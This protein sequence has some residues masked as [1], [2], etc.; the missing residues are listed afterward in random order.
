MQTDHRIHRDAETTRNE[1]VDR[2]AF[3]GCPSAHGQ[4]HLRREPAREDRPGDARSCVVPAAS[5]A[6]RDTTGRRRGSLRRRSQPSGGPADGARRTA[7]AGARQGSD[8]IHRRDE[9]HRL[10]EIL[11]GAALALQHAPAFRRQAVEAAAALARLFDPPALQ[12]AAFLE[13]IEEPVE[14]RDV[15]FELAVRAALD[16]LV[17]GASSSRRRK[18]SSFRSPSN[19]GSMRARASVNARSSEAVRCR[20]AIAVSVSPRRA[21]A[22]AA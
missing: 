8:M 10:D 17:Q 21:C 6:R 3:E 12:P 7:A 14:R 1:S 15:E 19:S 9:P 2:S 4:G 22:A 5:P 18:R 20:N 11:P 13:A 16:L